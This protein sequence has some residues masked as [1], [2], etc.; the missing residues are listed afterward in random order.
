METLNNFMCRALG[1]TKLS[2]PAWQISILGLCTPLLLCGVEFADRPS[3]F[4]QD[5]AFWSAFTELTWYKVLSRDL[6]VPLCPWVCG[7][8]WGML[9]EEKTVEELVTSYQARQVSHW[10]FRE[11]HLCLLN[12]TVPE[13]DRSLY[14]WNFSEGTKWLP[15]EDAGFLYC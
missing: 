8:E 1:N 6:E 3:Y 13:W 2:V 11:F 10:A 14:Y 12:T 5:F 15:S 7:R 4:V 9:R